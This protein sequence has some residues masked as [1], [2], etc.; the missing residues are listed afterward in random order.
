M[1]EKKHGQA[2]RSAG[3]EVLR[4][5]LRTLT[6]AE[7]RVLGKLKRVAYCAGAT[8]EELVQRV[9]LYG[10]ANAKTGILT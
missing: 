6:V 1:D 5:H 9:S 2:A 3:L 7:L 10:L 4:A 8:K